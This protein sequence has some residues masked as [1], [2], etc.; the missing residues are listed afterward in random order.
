MSGYNKMTWKPIEGEIMTR[1]A[2]EVE[3]KNPLPAYP[4]PQMKRKEWLNLNGLWDYAIRPNKLEYNDV[5]DGQILVPFP[6]ESTLSGVKI[7]LK[8]KHKLWYRRTFT[9]PDRWKGK[10]VILNFGAVDW[11]A[12]IYLNGKKIGMH[13]GG[14]VPFSFDITEHLSPKKENEL[15]VSVWDNTRKERGKQ[16]L[17]PFM[18]YYTAVSGIWQTV[19]LEPVSKTYI[20]NLKINTDIDKETLSLLVKINGIETRERLIVTVKDS[21]NVIVTTT[22]NSNEPIELYVRR[23]KL[24]QPDFPFLYSLLIKLDRDGT[25]IDEIESYF[26][27]R[28]IALGKDENGHV[29]I[30]LNG[31]QIFQYGTLDQGYWPDG[32]YTAPNDEA[33]LYDIEMTK[34]FGFNMIRKHVKVEPLRWYYYCDKMGIL[35]WQ[36]MPNGGWMIL[37]NIKKSSKERF[38]KE[39]KAMMA[40][41]HN[42]PSI[43]CWVPFNE[44]WGQF[45]TKK[46]TKMI[47]TADPSRL[48]DSASG[49]FDKGV[50]N[51][52]DIHVY[53][54]PKMP[55]EKSLK[56]RAAVIGEFGG[57]G[58]EVEDH[59]WKSKFKFAYRKYKTKEELTR[60]YKE[61]IM[62]LKPMIKD[63]LCA[64][65][66]TEITDVEMEINGLLTYDREIIK[67]DVDK[68]KNIHENLFK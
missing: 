57:Y 10:N 43:I 1:W 20:E 41:L 52:K 27:M 4:R 51:I 44:G 24:W 68:L 67:I 49:W 13:Q 28:K 5:Y 31:K 17:R 53:P 46:I 40:T 61:L 11:E 65:I 25:I 12:T 8:G 54:G 58:W 7:K 45:D 6:I 38:I 21:S 63:G 64:A 37:K 14:Y 35:V 29:R 30:E 62:K 55:K 48:V 26:G 34:K 66:Y 59:V 9:I 16:T 47:K 50:G 2:K 42:S 39:L 56:G 60:K 32:L 33:L 18:I 19:W 23:P 22:A 3:P 36:D 15:V